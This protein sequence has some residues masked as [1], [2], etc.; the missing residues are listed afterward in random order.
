M[1][2]S[3]F[4]FG[5]Y[6]RDIFSRFFFLGLQKILVTVLSEKTDGPHRMFSFSTVVTLKIRSKSPKSNQFLVMS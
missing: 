6:T 2:K 4:Y 1:F 3:G 5:S